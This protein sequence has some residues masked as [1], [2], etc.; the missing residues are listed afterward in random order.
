MPE[1]FLYNMS[2]DTI[3]LHNGTQTVQ[4]TP[5]KEHPRANICYKT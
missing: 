3:T 1:S 2:H 5:L 4:I